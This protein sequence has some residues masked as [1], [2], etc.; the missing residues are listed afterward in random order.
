MIDKYLAVD[1]DV[2]LAN[3]EAA[4]WAKLNIGMDLAINMT[5]GIEKLLK[6]NDY[7]YI[8][9]NS[10][11][12]DFLPL[13]K[14]MRSVTNIPIIIS[15]TNF[16]TEMEVAALERGADLFIRWNK[17]TEENI[18]S[19]L[20]HI[21]RLNERNKTLYQQSKIIVY[22]DLLLAPLQQCV[23]VDNQKIM[24]TEKECSV[25]YL[26]MTNN[27]CIFTPKEI[28][29]EVWKSEFNES[30]KA[31]IW[32][33]IKNLRKKIN[34]GQKSSRYITTM[35]NVGYSFNPE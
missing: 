15:T 25:L 12:V 30:S 1:G 11:T 21:T 6:R 10:D 3:S 20:A 23:Y 26:L 17:N 5:Q 32:K 29:N 28:Y 35:R 2:E 16:T 33:T 13:L 18:A 27:G 8:G 31:I 19:V 9:I 7:L 22:N 34:N 14:A 24:L 4:V